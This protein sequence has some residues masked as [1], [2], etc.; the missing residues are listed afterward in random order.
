MPS[1]AISLL[2]LVVYSYLI[3]E[4]GWRRVLRQLGGLYD[5]GPARSTLWEWVVSRKD[6]GAERDLD[7]LPLECCHQLMY[8]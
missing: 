3:A 1:F 6:K 5:R 8:A 7:G 4:R 2:H